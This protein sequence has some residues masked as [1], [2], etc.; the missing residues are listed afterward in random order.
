MRSK[1]QRRIQRILLPTDLKTG[2]EAALSLPATLARQLWA[3][4][5]VLHVDTPFT[6]EEPASRLRK[7]ARIADDHPEVPM[8]ALSRPGGTPSAAI[9]EYAADNDVDLIVMAATRL[10]QGFGHLLG[11][12]A[13]EV[14]DG[15][16]CPVLTVRSGDAA[17]GRLL[18][19]VLVPVDFSPA[20]ADALELAA[21]IARAGKGELVLLHV[22]AEQGRGR[23]RLRAQAEARLHSLAATIE[24][25]VPTSTQLRAGNPVDAIVRCSAELEADLVVIASHASAGRRMWVGSVA[26]E[27]QRF[28]ASP[29]L[30]VKGASSDEQR[31]AG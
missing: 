25:P 12:V 4:L 20:G 13:R 22:I 27:V 15:S 2:G 31:A 29:V 9:L 18:V 28:A 6:A 21:E 24:P 23:S 17:T 1:T 3:S 7:L 19:R 8:V 10:H 26:K 14:V 5:H 30:L 11:S 16:D